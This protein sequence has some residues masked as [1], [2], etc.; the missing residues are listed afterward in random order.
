[1][2]KIIL[3]LLF[4]AC[5]YGAQA[6]GDWRDTL[7]KVKDLAGDTG[8]AG[9]ARKAAPAYITGDFEEKDRAPKPDF[10]KPIGDPAQ[11]AGAVREQERILGDERRAGQEALHREA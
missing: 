10:T 2:K 8:I 4:A 7:G 3:T 6:D 11:Y 1:M 9:F 5:A